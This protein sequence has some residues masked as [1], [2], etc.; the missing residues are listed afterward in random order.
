MAA[1]L[2]KPASQGNFQHQQSQQPAQPSKKIK[3]CYICHDAYVL[4]DC[5]YRINVPR[6]QPVYSLVEEEATNQQEYEYPPQ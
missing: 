2:S 3:R 1:I 4:N 6:F 5:P